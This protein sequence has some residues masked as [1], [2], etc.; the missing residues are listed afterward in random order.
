MKARRRLPRQE[1]KEVTRMRLTRE[2]ARHGSTS[3]DSAA[4][5]S[6]RTRRFRWPDS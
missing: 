1:S 4:W 6:K 2:I 3:P 5:N